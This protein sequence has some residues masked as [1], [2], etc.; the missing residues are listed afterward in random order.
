V[1]IVSIMMPKNLS[2]FLID[3]LVRYRQGCA[4]RIDIL[5]R[6]IRGGLKSPAVHGPNIT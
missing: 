2:T 5:D 3:L 1:P 6:V 4:E